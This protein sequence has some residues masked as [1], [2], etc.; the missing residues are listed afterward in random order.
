MIA[1]RPRRVMSRKVKSY[2][3]TTLK[4]LPGHKVVLYVSGHETESEMFQVNIFSDSSPRTLI[5]RLELPMLQYNYI[6]IPTDSRANP[7][8]IVLA[9]CTW[10]AHETPCEIVK[11]VQKEGKFKAINSAPVSDERL[12]QEF[13][14]CIRLDQDKVLVSL[15][16]MLFILDESLDT[17]CRIDRQEIHPCRP[18]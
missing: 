2:P 14:N 16:A 12:N 1:Q 4:H 15:Q 5:N 6:A 18:D 17:V 13:I 8:S 3:L 7:D 11:V 9:F 10:V